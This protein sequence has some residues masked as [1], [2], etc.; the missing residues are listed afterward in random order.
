VREYEQHLWVEGNNDFHFI[1]GLC[2]RFSLKQNFEIKDLK[3][4]EKLLKALNNRLAEDRGTLGIVIDADEQ[5]QKRWKSVKDKLKS[6]GYDCP[7]TP[8][9]SGTILSHALLPGVGIWMMP[10][11]EAPG[12]LEDLVRQLIPEGDELVPKVN[13]TL[14][15]LEVSN[16]ARYASKDRS[17]AF[18][19]TWLAWQDTPGKP[20]GQG[21]SANYYQLDHPVS[22]NLVNWMKELFGHP[23]S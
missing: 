22:A 6:L 12:K 7:E 17:K 19:H 2:K 13:E 15:E 1:S 16:I 8:A 11:N 4:V 9:E 14:N 23:T 5:P 18:I 3:G 20:M 21:I 10:N